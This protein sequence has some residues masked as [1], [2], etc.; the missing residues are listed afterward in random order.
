MRSFRVGDR[1]GVLR[2]D[3]GKSLGLRKVDAT[4]IRW[5]AKLRNHS[6][7]HSTVLGDV[8]AEFDF[9]RAR[10]AALVWFRSYGS[11]ITDSNYTVQQACRDY[12]EDRRMEKSEACLPALAVSAAR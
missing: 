1:I 11:G 5:I 4:R 3:R 6:G 10:E 12:V 8:T 2:W 9:E 7:H